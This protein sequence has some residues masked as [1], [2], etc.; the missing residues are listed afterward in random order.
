MADAESRAQTVPTYGHLQGALCPP[1]TVPDTH[2]EQ[3]TNEDL[4]GGPALIVFFPF[5]FTPICAA[6]LAELDDRIREF[7][8]VAILAVSCD[9]VASLRA[10]Q[11]REEF[12]FD[13]AS[14]FWPHGQVA[15]AFG[16][17]DEATGHPL[18]ASFI[19]DA[20]GTITWSVINPA[21]MGRPVDDYLKALP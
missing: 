11:E 2:G 8:D 9:A 17:L 4:R 6:E 16:V 18:R 19:L 14:D 20:R 3:V 13:M 15:R 1:F 12:A 21:G 7:D 5:A 10:W